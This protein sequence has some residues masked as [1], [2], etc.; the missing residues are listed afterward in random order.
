M[1]LQ[2]IYHISKSNYAYAYGKKDLDFRLRTTRDDCTSVRIVISQKHRWNEKKAYAMEKIASDRLFDYYGCHYHTDDPRL[3]YYFEIGDG[4]QTLVYSESGFSKTFNDK[5][6]YF[7]Y[8]QYPYISEA[9]LLLVPEWVHTTV[10]YQIFV[11]RFRNGDPSNDPERLTPWGEPPGPHSFYGGDLQGILEKLPYLQKLGINGIYLTPIFQSDSNHKYDTIDYRRVDESFGTKKLLRELVAK[12]HS[13][14]IR[15]ILDGVFNHCS[16]RFE[17]FRDV[18]KRGEQSLYRDWFLVDGFPLA[19][20][21]EKEVN[22]YS[23][24]LNLSR[25][26]YRIFGTSPSMPKLNT[27]NPGLNRYLLETAAMW[28]KDTGIDGWRLDVSDEVSHSFW[29]DFRKTVKTINP[30][31][32]IIGENWHNAYPWL[33]GDQFDGVMNYA[34]TK[35]CIQ[36]FARHEIST[37]QFAADVSGYLMRNF[38]QTN[39][40]MLNLLDSHDTMRFLTWCGGDKR[41]LR[42][43]L[44]FLFSYV[45][46]PCVYYGSEIGMEG[47]GD[48]DCRRTFDWNMD[49]WDLELF[50]FYQQIIRI[51]ESEEALQSGTIRIRAENGVL[52][53]QRVFEGSRLVTAINNTERENS[54]SPRAGFQILLS[55]DC[56]E[57]NVLKPY[58][59]CICKMG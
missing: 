51:R 37:E 56:M 6:A 52:Y 45:G 14:G 15:I 35:S 1:N 49:N 32:L 16:W 24:P 22:D 48:P 33:Q 12:A 18:L 26:N 10:F 28:T 20:F 25:L 50:H 3:G 2:G 54:I 5:D 41:L 8:F 44:L 7:H 43:A 39:F 40:A 27:E 13:M 36:F 21:S 46:M 47:K 34:V 55:T 23:K 31:A 11:E 4:E 42:I 19:R 53:L 29:R 57:G 38:D 30:E 59:G 17:P 9:D 58:S